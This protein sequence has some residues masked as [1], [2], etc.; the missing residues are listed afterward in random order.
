M[1]ICVRMLAI[2]ALLCAGVAC[3]TG[4]HAATG[5]RLPPDGNVEKG[6]VAFLALEC[7]S[8]HTVP[9]VDLANAPAQ[10]STRIVLGGDVTHVVTDGYL[11]GAIVNPTRR[12]AT[13]AREAGGSG[14][15]EMP[16]Y[17][18]RMNVRQLTDIVAFLQSHYTVREFHP[19]YGYYYYN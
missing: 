14:P 17:A 19:K 13:S 5:F 7:N 3:D 6:K 16:L 18:D 9:G 15:L 11:V 8:C 1:W 10:P 2:V 12:H 4:R